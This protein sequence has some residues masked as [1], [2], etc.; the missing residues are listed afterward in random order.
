MTA[1]GSTAVTS[2][3]LGS[4]EPVPAP[5][6]RT[7]LASPSAAQ[8]C[9]AIRG[10]M[11]TP[12]EGRQRLIDT[13]RQDFGID[14]HHYVE[15]SFEGFGRLVDAVGGVP[16]FF[17]AA[18]RDRNSGLFQDQ[19]GC[20]TLNGQQA[21]QFVRARHL[22]YMT[23]EGEWRYDRTGDLGRVTRQQIFIEEA[24]GRTL[25]QVRSSP[26]EITHLIDIG[27]DTVGLDDQLGLSDI[28]DL[29]ERFKSF[30]TS[31]LRTYALPFIE[32]GDGATLAVDERNAEPILNVFRGLDPGE[33]SP[34]NI[35]VTVLNGSGQQDQAN[36]VAGA[37]QVIGFDVAGTGNAPGGL[38]IAHSQIHFRPGDDA[39]AQ[40]LARHITGGADLVPDPNTAPGTV[41]L[42]TGADLAT[43]HDQ[44]AP[45]DETTTTMAA[46]G[47]DATTTTTA[48]TTTSAPATTT[49]RPPA[50]ADAPGH[51]V[52]RP[53]PGASC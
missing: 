45:T 23:P 13:I 17:E 10:S 20:V 52:G 53:S 6:F 40:R 1:E 31:N 51:A 8:T 35:T 22:E 15:V 25:G 29:A 21:L 50:S 3:S 36:D 5:T 27:I 26:T 42:W 48:A 44:P 32:R 43:I 4:Y 46:R 38:P 28:R 33:V 18:V 11:G 24:L 2:R 39:A 41:A 9:S 30:D 49:T 14:L 16:L 19:L 37:L 12:D 7:V 34:A 47:D